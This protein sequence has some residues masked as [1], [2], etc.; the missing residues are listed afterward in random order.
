MTFASY[1]R[2]NNFIKLCLIVLLSCTTS[3]VLAQSACDDP[4]DD[5]CTKPGGCD[6]A[7]DKDSLAIPRLHA[8]DPND[9]IGPLGYD[10]IQ[11]MSI[12]DEFGFT[13]RFENDPDFATGPAQ[14][15][16]IN[17]PIHEKADLASVRLSTFG[18]GAF[19][20][21]PPE[22]SSFYADRLDVID[23]LGVF[24]DVTAGI[25]VNKKEVF[26]IFES[27]DPLTGLA[28]LEGDV[29]FLPVNDTTV[30]IYTDTI[31]QQGEGFVSFTLKPKSTDL[32]GDTIR[33]QAFI[34]F[35]ENEEIPTNTW[36]N[37]VDAFGPTTVMDTLPAVVDSTTFTLNWTAEDDPGGVGVATYDL[38]VSVDSN[39][40]YLYESEL[41][42]TA[43]DFTGLDGSTYAF[44]IRA[45][46]LVG[47]EEEQKFIEDAM[48]KIGGSIQISTKVFL[49]GPYSSA[50]GLMS[51]LLRSQSLIPFANPYT[52]Y[53]YQFADAD[54]LISEAAILD[55][56]GSDAIV[57]WIYLELFDMGL[58]E[59]ITGL[60]ALLQRD[61]DIVSTDGVTPITFSDLEDGNYQIIIYHRNHIPIKTIDNTISID[62]ESNVI[63][64]TNNISIF[65]GGVNAVK[66]IAG[67]Y[68]LISGDADRDGQIQ[69]ADIIE[70]MPKVG[71]TGYLEGDADMNGQIQN[72][73]IQNYILPNLGRGKQFEDE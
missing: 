16:R 59:S 46:D 18:F 34:V 11:W 27:I 54:Q 12:N 9:I 47:N 44:Y 45:K 20:F 7:T 71:Q 8:V 62:S 28:P 61:G 17:C 36:A 32:T 21:N 56:T 19:I 57:D 25:D 51:D 73:D 53:N 10:S 38:Y 31:V 4:D 5:P 2:Y 58:G 50:D 24:V 13:I 48:T 72:T 1:L 39:Q 15:V 66:E 63:D 22:N 42:T 70:A 30:T 6:P 64:L 14:V 3:L 65:I 68:T 67:V 41:D 26:W 29:G 40:Y 43:Y 69:N 52:D 55:V 35:D 33:E 60:A 49:Q 37:I 23:S